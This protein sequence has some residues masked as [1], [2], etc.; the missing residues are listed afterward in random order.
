M[1]QYRTIQYVR[2]QVY[3]V[4]DISTCKISNR[5]PQPLLKDLRKLMIILNGAVQVYTVQDKSTCKVSNM[6]SQAVPSTRLLQ[7]RMVKYRRVRY[8]RV[9]VYTRVHARFLT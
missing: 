8:V 7:F 4:Q 5:G 2:V 3:T 1:V 6:R 9:Q